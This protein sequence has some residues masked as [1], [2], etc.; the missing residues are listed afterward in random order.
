[1]VTFI[2]LVTVYLN[3]CDHRSR[4]PDDAIENYKIILKKMTTKK[5]I[6]SH[7]LTPLRMRVSR[8]QELK[9]FKIIVCTGKALKTV[10]RVILID[11]L[12]SR[13]GSARRGGEQW[14]RLAQEI[15]RWIRSIVCGRARAGSSSCSPSQY[16]WDR[17]YERCT[18]LASQS[19]D[20]N[21]LVSCVPVPWLQ[22]VGELRPEK[23]G[24]KKVK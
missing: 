6:P 14:A 18:L 22:S 9:V 15:H 24:P 16:V 17:F 23:K 4:R 21:Q 2:T 7:T 10:A 8:S 3:V 12:S 5:K 11:V 19:P 13:L 1:M 20:Y